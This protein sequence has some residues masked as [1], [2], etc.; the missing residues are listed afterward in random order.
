MISI[1]LDIFLALYNT[2]SGWEDTERQEGET[3]EEK[4]G[5]GNFA[6]SV[7][8]YSEYKLQ[9]SETETKRY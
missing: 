1:L 9:L 3:G 7:V 6:A 4:R 5:E 8:H 2:T